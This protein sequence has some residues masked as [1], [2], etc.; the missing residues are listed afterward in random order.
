MQGLQV[1]F[2]GAVPLLSEPRIWTGLSLPKVMLCVSLLAADVHSLPSLPLCGL[3]AFHADFAHILML[4]HCMIDCTG[5]YNL[6]SLSSLEQRAPFYFQHVIQTGTSY[7]PCVLPMSGSL[8]D[9]RTFDPST[10]IFIPPCL[11]LFGLL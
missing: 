7:L 6:L 2:L 5:Q 11:S 1:I 4:K 3:L 10:L 9:P 8:E